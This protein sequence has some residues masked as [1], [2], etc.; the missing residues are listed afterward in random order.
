MDIKNILCINSYPTLDLHGV[1]RETARVLVND[2]VNE[3]Y[4]LKKEFIV[5]V[6]GIGSGIVKKV[7]HDTLKLNKRVLEYY[8]AYNN[9]GSTIV[10][11]DI[12]A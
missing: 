12:R 6:H 3:Q 2:F 9:N 5:I 1:D 11:L 8:T 4:K 10:K 7:T